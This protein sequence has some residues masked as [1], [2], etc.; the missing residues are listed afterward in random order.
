MTLFTC[1]LIIVAVI[2]TQ[3]IKSWQPVGLH[4]I[5]LDLM[6]HTYLFI[7]VKI[8]FDKNPSLKESFG[9]SYPTPP[10]PPLPLI[11]G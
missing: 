2:P 6:Q 5:L 3:E 9:M 8:R 4:Q 1:K 7:F 10:L 11:L